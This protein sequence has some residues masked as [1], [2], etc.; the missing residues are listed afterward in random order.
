NDLAKQPI[1]APIG[2]YDLVRP[3]DGI[4][5]GEEGQEYQRAVAS[6]AD[7]F[8]HEATLLPPINLLRPD[9]MAPAGVFGDHTLNTGG[10]ILLSHRFN[11]TS[12]DGLRDGTHG[13]S[14]ASVLGA[15]PIA[16]THET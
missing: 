14:T 8:Y 1:Y 5:P 11:N 9:G 6:E 10:Q 15:F 2:Q 13:V 7:L 4:S 12:F 3:P 16:P